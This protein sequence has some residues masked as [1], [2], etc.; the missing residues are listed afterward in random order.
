GSAQL[1]LYVPGFKLKLNQMFHQKY[2]DRN[3][4]PSDLNNNVDMGFCSMAHL[5]VLQEDVTNSSLDLF[6]RDNMNSARIPHDSLK[7]KHRELESKTNGTTKKI[8]SCSESVE[9]EIV[10]PSLDTIK[11]NINKLD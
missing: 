1:W 2:L 10:V 6:G 9:L 11:T 3:F 7:R 4:K 5:K 8:R